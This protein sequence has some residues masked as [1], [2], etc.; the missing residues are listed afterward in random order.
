MVPGFVLTID[1][2]TTNLKCILF[3]ENGNEVLRVTRPNTTRYLKPFFAEQ[4]P[5]QWITNLATALRDMEKRCPEGVRSIQAV[6][7][8]GQMHGPV[9]FDVK[10][11]RVL[12]PCIIWSDT[13]ATEELGVL[14]EVFSQEFFLETMGNPLQQSFTL[15]KL[16]WLKHHVPEVFE[17]SF[18][19][20]F[21]KDYIACVLGG[22]IA[23]DPSDASGSLMFD[24][25]KRNWA[26]EVLQELGFPCEMLPD[27][28]PSD[29]VVGYVSKEAADTFSL[30]MGVPIVK[31]GGDLATTALATGAGTEGNLSICVGTAGQLLVC[32][33]EIEREV[34]GKLYV[35][36]HCI[37]DKYFY[38]GTVPAGGA[39]LEWFLSLFTSHSGQSFW[40]E[41]ERIQDIPL[42]RT[43][44][45]Y[46]FLLGTGTP[47][48]DYQAEAAFFGLQ[49]HHRVEDVI[50]AILE[51]ISFALRESAEAVP[52]VWEK[53]N[54]IILS[55]GLARCPLFP[56]IVSYVFRRP[57]FLLRYVDAASVGAFLLA[58]K[59]LGFSQ[60][61]QAGLQ[62]AIEREVIPLESTYVRYYD[63]LYGLYKSFLKVVLSFASKGYRIRQ[64][65]ETIHGD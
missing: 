9:L 26:R 43:L 10:E 56:K 13:R 8:T 64:L 57:V 65:W 1:V 15:P 7:L 23:T 35:F 16:L 11:K 48:F 47:H 41:V 32:A 37:W 12:Y 20:L 33:N 27:V 17:E 45:F 4:D 31:G 51:G 36:L 54:Q 30:P 60:D 3:D 21:P 61:C 5:S 40:K 28:V 18:K 62:V 25:W 53:V 42:Q 52:P 24:L 50:V 46:P 63:E 55:G 22:T 59:A 39:S 34:L 29:S 38:L 2:G 44:L 49:M 58:A 19:I 14:R 6:S